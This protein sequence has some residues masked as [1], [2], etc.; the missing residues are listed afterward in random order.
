ME[1]GSDSCYCFCGVFN[2]GVFSVFLH[3]KNRT[4]GVLNFRTT[5]QPI[6]LLPVG[7]FCYASGGAGPLSSVSV[8]SRIPA[9]FASS[10]SVSSMW[11]AF[12]VKSIKTALYIPISSERVN[13]GRTIRW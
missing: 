10:S 12:V 13:V 6:G 11:S 5:I 8:L 3:S 2:T 9:S 1:R 7:C 4:F